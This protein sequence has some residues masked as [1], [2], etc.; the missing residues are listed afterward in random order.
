MNTSWQ[1]RPFFVFWPSCYWP[2]LGHTRSRN[3]CWAAVTWLS[4]RPEPSSR[5]EVDGLN[6]GGQHGRRFVL[7]RHTHVCSSRSGNVQHRCGG[8]WAGP[9]LLSEGS[10]QEGGC[11]CQG[12]KSEFRSVVQPFRLPLVIRPKRRTSDEL[13]CGEH[14]WVF[15]FEAPCICTPG[16]VSAEWS[17]CPGST[18]RRA[19]DSVAPMRRSSAGWIPARMGGCPLV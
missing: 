5:A 4:H 10:F 9:T 15:R 16:Q 8:G 12:W 14:K 2:P 17:G 18:A 19:G 13:L 7:L 11:W 1:Q 6:I 3:R